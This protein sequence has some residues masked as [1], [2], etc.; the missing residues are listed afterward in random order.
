MND[1]PIKLA[2]L[3]SGSGTTLQNLIDQI[4]TQSLHAQIDLVVASRPEIKG[5]ARAEAAGIPVCVINRQEYHSVNHFSK[6]VFTEI[7]RLNIDLICLAGWLSLLNIPMRYDNKLMNI[8]PALLPSF[9]GRGMFGRHVHQAV[10]DYGSKVSGCTVHFLDNEYDQ[11]PIILQRTVPVLEDDTA[12]TLAANVFAEEKIAY[13][14]A[15][16]LYQQKRLRIEGRC[17]RVL[18][19]KG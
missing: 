4:A 19:R 3:I 2:V 1:A 17:V 9:G 14:E 7:N 16:R 18:P 13:P 8:H 15:I 6:R 11:G 5:I 10:L 12:E